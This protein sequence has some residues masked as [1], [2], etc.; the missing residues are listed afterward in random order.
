M[1]QIWDFFFLSVKQFR[2]RKE[3]SLSSKIPVLTLTAYVDLENHLTSLSLASSK[4]LM[5][6]VWPSHED[7][8]RHRKAFS[9][10]L[11]PC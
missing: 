2:I 4:E 10:W 8:V 6:V 7:Q 3:M 1:S 11:G 5:T 9:T